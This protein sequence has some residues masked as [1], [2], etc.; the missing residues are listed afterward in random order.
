MAL[1]LPSTMRFVAGLWPKESSRGH[2]YFVGVNKR[3]KVYLFFDL[4]ATDSDP[5][6]LLYT[7]ARKPKTTPCGGRTGTVAGFTGG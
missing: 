2:A 6:W 3:E 5:P 4:D 1:D 7:E